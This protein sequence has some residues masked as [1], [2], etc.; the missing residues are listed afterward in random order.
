MIFY[1]IVSNK[2]GIFDAATEKSFKDNVLLQVGTVAP[3]EL[4]ICFRG[5]EPKV[6][7]L[8]KRASLLKEIGFWS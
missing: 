2:K 3:M 7:A 6:D 1:S 5:Q 4:Y 8:L